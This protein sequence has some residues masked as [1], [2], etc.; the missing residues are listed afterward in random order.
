[1]LS[2]EVMG[3]CLLARKR[4]TI[5]AFLMHSLIGYDSIR[6]LGRK[7]IKCKVLRLEAHQGNVSVMYS[8]PV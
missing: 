8:E 1:M 6:G 2:D 5:S 4:I 3:E 7:G